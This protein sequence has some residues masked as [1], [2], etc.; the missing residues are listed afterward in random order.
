MSIQTIVMNVVC[1][2]WCLYFVGKSAEN[3]KKKIID[4]GA[5]NAVTIGVLF[6]FIGIAWSLY[7]FDTNPDTMAVNIQNFLDGMKTAFCTS[8][9]GM[10]F[11]LYIK[12]RQIG[13]EQD[14]DKDALDS[15]KHLNRLNQLDELYSINGEIKN[16]Q[17]TA[18]YNNKAFLDAITSQS[19]MLNLRLSSISAQLQKQHDDLDLS[20][21]KEFTKALTNIS[22]DLNAF[23]QEQKNNS[24]NIKDSFESNISKLGDTLGKRIEILTKNM[25]AINHQQANTTSE[26]SNDIAEMKRSTISFAKDMNN[27]LISTR[28]YQD[29]SLKNDESFATVMTNNTNSIIQMKES[30]DD[31]LKNMAEN[32]SSELIHALNMSM[33]KLNTQLQTQFGENFKELNS[34]VKE[35]VVWQENYKD[36]VNTS[37]EELKEINKI[38][39]NFQDTMQKQFVENLAVLSNAIQQF[40]E[41]TNTNKDA[42]QQ[43]QEVTVTLNKCAVEGKQNTESMH[44]VIHKL[45]DL[46][47]G[48]KENVSNAV[49]NTNKTIA[50][51]FENMI[52]QQSDR[53][54]KYFNELKEEE[55]AFE[56]SIK[57][58]NR[59][60][61]DVTTDVE[62]Y[63]HDFNTTSKDIMKQVRLTLEAFNSDFDKCTKTELGSL[64]AIFEQLAKNTDLQQDKA[65][66][67]L[68]GTLGVITTR[69]IGDYNALI[70]K[71]HDLDV[72]IQNEKEGR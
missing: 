34:A 1:F 11:G 61:F 6:T 51:Q 3:I 20:S 24:T 18:S 70:N 47:D 46:S 35:T 53:S 8:I 21:I 27:L 15:L 64:K 48:I 12:S 63:L 43:L 14:S 54:L 67:Q 69:I 26:I 57:K 19:N 16:F 52:K 56:E 60:A 4:N 49:D 41:T 59:K 30:F 71:I 45:N 2:I 65:I 38:F 72:L 29:K 66:K 37:T 68:A 40:T 55:N 25:Q 31:F 17:N 50:T 62:Q 42:Q 33:D 36:I 13:V 10:L 7:F 58:L 44:E 22:S 5:Q 9:I 28:D 32:Y 39:K 23:S